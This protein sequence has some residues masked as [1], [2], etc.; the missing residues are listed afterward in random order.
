MQ[1][2]PNEANRLPP[3][4]PYPVLDLMEALWENAPDGLVFYQ[5][6]RD[7]TN[8]PI[9]FRYLR[10]NRVAAA[11]LSTKPEALVGQSSQFI[12]S[13]GVGLR[14]HYQQVVLTG[15]TSVYDYELPADGR[16]FEV[17]ITYP[18]PDILL[19]FFSDKTD[20]QQYQRELRRENRRLNE[21]Q[22]VGKVGSFEWN[23]GESS[24]NWS[25][26]L[27]R[28][29]G[30]SPQ[31]KPITVEMVSHFFHP[32]DQL[33][34]ET[35][36][37]ESFRAAGSYGL[38]HR[39][40]R[41]DGGVVWVNHQYESIADS[42][43]QV[44]RVH[45]TVQDISE[46]R[47][48]QRQLQESERRFRDIAEHVDEIFWIQDF[49]QPAFL[50]INPA[51]QTYS[52]RSPQALLTN[53]LSFL[54][55]IPPED[56]SLVEEVFLSPRPPTSFR[57]RI[58][59]LDGRLFW[60]Q[61]R[62]F[63]AHDPAGSPIHRIGV[64]TDITTSI[65]KERILEASL[66]NERQLN[67]LKSQFIETASHE[68]RT[69]LA[70]I[71]SS[72][73]LIEHYVGR[74]AET[75]ST[76]TIRRHLAVIADKITALESLLRDTLTLSKIDAGK[77]ELQ[78]EWTDL[79]SFSRSLF[80]STYGQTL[81]PQRPVHL[82]V[83]GTPAAVKVDRKLLGH[84]LTNLLDN[85]LKFSRLSPRLTL[86]FDPNVVK[87]AVSDSGIGI[88][89]SEQAY[90]FS[91]FFRATNA[92]HIQGMGLGLAIC[93]QYVGLLQGQIE[94]VSTE[95]MGTTFTVVLPYTQRPSSEKLID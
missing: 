5:V 35:L 53:P 87:L 56:R 47:L 54:D 2:P 93:E 12:S 48:T 80:E 66:A 89:A 41:V 78:L 65:E 84:V 31:A 69:P 77:I 33:A 68:F 76:P 16:C 26:E 19:C 43:G 20:R 24:V 8:R 30:M 1:L 62:L 58:R 83:E 59:H 39:S 22:I 88:P 13:Q 36:Q 79:V 63:T 85:G 4:Q 34:L 10:V 94:L 11:L 23:L 7:A 74:E 90:I 95:G 73:D 46:Y 51:Y 50:Y 32:D 60:M 28:I 75:S 64:A 9:D 55:G 61:A 52:G 91:K 17:L 70:A 42:S 18:L 6:V 92:N 3:F 67:Q 44:V 57:F 81:A 86:Q 14:T 38:V 45:G 72:V 27:Y 40:Q 29:H 71:Q 25:D 15:R 82:E 21:A 49:N 37:H